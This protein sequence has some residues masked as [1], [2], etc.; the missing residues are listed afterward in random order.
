MVFA[1]VPHLSRDALRD[2]TP[3]PVTSA[4][5]PQTTRRSAAPRRRHS[6][7][8]VFVTERDD[9]SNQE[10][11][12][13][14]ATSVDIIRTLTSECKKPTDVLL[15]LDITFNIPRAGAIDKKS[16]SSFS[17]VALCHLKT[18]DG[19]PL[20]DLNVGHT[21]VGTHTTTNS[22]YLDD[23]SRWDMDC[24]P[25]T[26]QSFFSGH[27]D[28]ETFYDSDVPFPLSRHSNVVLENMRVKKAKTLAKAR[29]G[30]TPTREIS[31]SK[32]DPPLFSCRT[33]YGLPGLPHPLPLQT[34]CPNTDARRKLNPPRHPITNP[35]VTR[36]DSYGITHLGS[37]DCE[38]SILF[39]NSS[40]FE[41]WD[42]GDK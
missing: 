31:L 36:R 1:S 11:R 28:D 42:M 23:L 13:H 29:S 12:H 5:P 17:T 2:C 37:V 27:I 16:I 22:Y 24:I 26:P 8:N 18:F 38:L 19:G 32:L 30:A 15:E 39:P 6:T 14:K 9:T 34:L 40:H 21:N 25:T 35:S 7:D 4:P 20:A 33:N 41:V 3:R 10:N